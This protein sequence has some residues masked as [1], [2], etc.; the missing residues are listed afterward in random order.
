MQDF[1]TLLVTSLRKQEIN[2]ETAA[3]LRAAMTL[4]GIA[5][6]T[7]FKWLKGNAIPEDG[8]QGG[9]IASLAK[10]LKVSQSSL[11][12]ALQLSRNLNLR[13]KRAHALDSLATWVRKQD[14]GALFGIATPGV[15]EFAPILAAERERIARRVARLRTAY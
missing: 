7:A 15:K 9:N 6:S 8:V 2:P 1:H 5:R 4:L 3:G 11:R 14:V 10:L 13:G 12:D